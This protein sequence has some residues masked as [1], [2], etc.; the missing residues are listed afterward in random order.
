[1]DE[2]VANEDYAYELL[3][4]PIPENYSKEDLVEHLAECSEALTILK[5]ALT[6]RKVI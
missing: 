1:M 4:K 3:K 5:Q 2:V 6:V